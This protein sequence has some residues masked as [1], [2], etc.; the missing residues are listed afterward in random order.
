MWPFR[1]RAKPE[2][3][4]SLRLGEHSADEDAYTVLTV[5]ESRHPEPFAA[6]WLAASDSERERGRIRRWA[7]LHPVRDPA[8]GVADIVVR[9]DD[10]TACYLR[11]P[12]LGR[13]ATRM[14][15]AHVL[16]LEVPAIIEWGPAGPTVRLRF[17]E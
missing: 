17:E 11:P 8:F 10:Q 4:G 2:A 9:F 14:D 16:C 13:A 12:H 15:D 3:T 1:R 6:M 7:S 5:S